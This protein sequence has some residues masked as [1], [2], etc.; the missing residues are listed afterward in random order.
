[1]TS[2]DL[3]EIKRLA[4]VIESV[5]PEEFN[6]EVRKAFLRTAP[7][8]KADLARTADAYMPDRYAGEIRKS[9]RIR[10]RKGP[11]KRVGVTVTASAKSRHGG[12]R[13]LGELNRGKL[14]HPTYGHTPWVDQRIKP[15]W[16]DDTFDREGD[17][18][19]QDVLTALDVAI[20]R[21]IRAH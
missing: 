18:V 15:G 6:R 3:R 11:G 20:R 16:S 19:R 21:I 2:I 13:H 10:T 9:L 1:M 17:T 4:A 14:R 7:R 8:V 12:S 5:A